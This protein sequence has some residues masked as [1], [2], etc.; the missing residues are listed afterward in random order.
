VATGIPLFVAGNN[1]GRSFKLAVIKL[2][3]AGI[4]FFKT[5]EVVIF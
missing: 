4:S 1:V 5:S 3:I 2:S